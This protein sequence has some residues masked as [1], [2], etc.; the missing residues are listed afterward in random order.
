MEEE[1][2][3]G[4]LERLLLFRGLAAGEPE[5]FVSR[6]GGRV[7]R[8]PKKTRLAY[9]HEDNR[10]IGVVVEG[11]V[12]IVLKDVADCE[13]L[14][15]ELR[16]DALFGNVWAVMGTDTYCGLTVCI[17]PK[18]T[19]LWLPYGRFLTGQAEPQ[20]EQVERVYAIVRKNLFALLSRM[21]FVMVQKIEVLS[22]HTLRERLRLY[23]RQLAK[24][25]GTARV[26][27]PS[28]VALAKM[29]ACNRSAMTREIG[30]LEDEGLLVCGDGWMEWKQE[31]NAWDE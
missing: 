18:T 22:Q 26:K 27:V 21:M 11:A 17:Q 5:A 23:L 6:M 8:F 10:Y 12:Q 31:K 2:G 15:Y 20:G 1:E 24:A 28:R 4:E 25:Q 29:L 30:R 7:Q 3:K 14:A 16:Q 19:V 9:R 13:V